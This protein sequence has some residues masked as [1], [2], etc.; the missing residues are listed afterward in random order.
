MDKRQQLKFCDWTLLFLM[1]V[2]LASSIQLEASDNRSTT[3]VWLHGI[4]ASVFIGFVVYHIK[5]HFGWNRWF[6]KFSKLKSSVTR[7]LWWISLITII[8]AIVALI[9]WITTFT[10]SP[11]GGVHGKIGFFMILV[12]IIHTKKRTAFFKRLIPSFRNRH[13]VYN[14]L[15]LRLGDLPGQRNP[16]DYGLSC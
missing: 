6:F 11:I 5:L 16:Q 15:A 7:L 4:I 2:T 10:H 3:F 12:A 1:I 9:H 13:K 14:F 8:S